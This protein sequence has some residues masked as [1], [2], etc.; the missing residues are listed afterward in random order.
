MKKSLFALAGALCF[1]VV[2]STAQAAPLGAAGNAS[3]AAASSEVI[4]VHGLHSSCKRD[5]RGWHR[6][7]LWGR[8]ACAPP[9][10][11]HHHGKKP[12]KPHHKKKH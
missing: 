11:R 1:G 2:A 12:G 6:S 9:H 8:Q 10:H 3:S 4:Q 7:H 5:G